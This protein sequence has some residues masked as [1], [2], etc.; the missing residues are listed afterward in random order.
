[1]DQVFFAYCILFSFFLHFRFMFFFSFLN[2]HWIFSYFLVQYCDLIALF[3]TVADCGMIIG[4]YCFYCLFILLVFFNALYL[5]CLVIVNCCIEEYFIYVLF[6]QIGLFESWTKG[7]FILVHF[8]RFN[9]C[10]WIYR[11]LDNRK[12]EISEICTRTISHIVGFRGFFPFLFLLIKIC[13]C[14][15]F[16][17]IYCFYFYINGCVLFVEFYQC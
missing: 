3:F 10:A 5:Y 12:S 7:L 6:L 11:K 14:Q 4:I 13:Q 16:F 8:G 15:H 17:F 1:M 9:R 2:L